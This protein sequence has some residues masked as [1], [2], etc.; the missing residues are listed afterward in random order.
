MITE[1]KFYDMIQNRGKKHSEAFFICFGA[2][3][4]KKMYKSL[5]QF[6]QF[7]AARPTFSRS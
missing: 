3:I 1:T 5:A 7:P 6:A 4:G 2:V